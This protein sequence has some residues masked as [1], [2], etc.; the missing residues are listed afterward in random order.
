MVRSVVNTAWKSV[1]PGKIPW[2][3]ADVDTSSKVLEGFQTL[4]YI[5]CNLQFSSSYWCGL[6]HMH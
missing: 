1:R 3:R 4:W 6:A 5:V 2:G